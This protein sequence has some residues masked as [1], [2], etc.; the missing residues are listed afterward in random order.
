MITAKSCALASL[1]PPFIQCQANQ[2]YRILLVEDDPD[3][4]RLTSKALLQ[5]GYE[6]DVAEDGETG[7]AELQNNRYNLLITKNDLPKLTG[8]GLLKKLRSACMPLPVIMVIE[9]MPTWESPQYSWLLNANKLLMPYSYD[10]LLGV[11]KKIQRATANIP[12]QMPSPTNW[13]RQLS[14]V[15]LRS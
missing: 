7:W 1:S 14:A 10:E 3:I 8:V 15:R 6:V 13:Q 11:V 9:T 5:H 12:V 2:I 4:G